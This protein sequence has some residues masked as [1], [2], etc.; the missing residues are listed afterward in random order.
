MSTRNTIKECRMPITAQDLVQVARQA[1]QE[2]DAEGL[3]KLREQ[4]MPIV[5]VREP[6]EYAAGHLPGAVNIPR[7]VLEF[8]VDDHPAVN[9][10]RDPALTHRDKPLVLYCRTG[11]RSALA[12][13]A[14]QRLGFAQPLSLQG[15]FNRWTSES[16]Q[17]ETGVAA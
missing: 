9:F 14:L 2:I 4:G 11:G 12:A 16:R 7:G 1:T 5:D 13:E 15:G 6:G 8:E 10:V 17:V 3:L